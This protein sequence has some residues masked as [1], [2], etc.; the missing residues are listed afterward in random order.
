MSK[1]VP[2][3]VDDTD[4][5]YG[6]KISDNEKESKKRGKSLSYLTLPLHSLAVKGNLGF[7]LPGTL[8]EISC[9]W[10]SLVL[11]RQNLLQ[12]DNIV[13]AIDKKRIGEDKGFT[14]SLM[15]I[16]MTFSN[17]V[18]SYCPTKI[19]AKIC[20]GGAGETPGFVEQQILH[21]IMYPNEIKFYSQVQADHVPVRIPRCFFA[22]SRKYTH[23]CLLEMV[24]FATPGDQESEEITLEKAKK[25]LRYLARFHAHF[26]GKRN[27]TGMVP[28]TCENFL[29]GSDL[30]LF[31]LIVKALMP[32][33]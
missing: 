26:W 4:A 10:M 16:N 17:P 20:G 7:E 1:V 27:M 24:T 30:K 22:A 12:T 33:T 11:Q 14:A 23:I 18:A 5:K 32:R 28:Q 15:L 9:E 29:A 31:P 19:V 25:V 3:E 21:K 13:T 8:E 2:W 6:V